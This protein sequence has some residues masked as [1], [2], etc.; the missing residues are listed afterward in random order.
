MNCSEVQELLSTYYD[1]ELAA[2][3]HKR[4]TEH[5]DDC[6]ACAQHIAGFERLSEMAA[7]LDT[8]T[9]PEIIWS[10]L[11]QQL[12][13]RPL[14]DQTAVVP[15]G[16]TRTTTFSVQRR[17][18]LAAIVLLAVGVGWFAYQ[19]RFGHEQHG[20]FT[21]DFGRYLQD[22]QRDPAA[23]QQFLLTKYD[24]QSVDTAQAEQ[25]LGYR[26]VVADGLPEGYSME[27]MHV[28]KMPCCTCVKCLCKRSDGSAIAIFEHNDDEMRE[29]FG[30]RPE[31][32]AT[33]GGKSCSLVDVDSRIAATWKRGKR[34]V[35]VIGARD[36]TEVDQ[37]VAWFDERRKG[38]IR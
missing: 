4:V 23:A 36:V 37:M 16:Q 7:A 32:S 9:A 30:D 12:E 21:A 1:G 17:F 2:D 11:E 10:E 18:A 34:H 22:F 20:P 28:M 31:R 8:P 14:D 6:S 3:M 13:Q 35:T 29:W 5:V 27:S 26:P 19:A 15:A 25:R 33:C 38:L 24:G